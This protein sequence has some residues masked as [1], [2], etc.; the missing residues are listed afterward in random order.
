MMNEMEADAAITRLESDMQDMA[1]RHRDLFA[2]ASAWAQRHD[3][4]IAATPADLRA[5]VEARLHR[6]AVRW[7]V[8]DGVRVTTQFPAFK[9]RA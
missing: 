7:G 2:Y 1:N 4:I 3:S 9:S 6:I 5:T 8:A